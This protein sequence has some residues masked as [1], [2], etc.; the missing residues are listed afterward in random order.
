MNTEILGFKINYT[1]EIDNLD[2]PVILF[3]HGFAD[4]QK[5][6]FRFKEFENKNF[7]FAS[8]DLPGSGLSSTDRHILIED[9]QN[10]LLEFVNKILVAE[11]E[12]YLVSHSLGSASV[13]YVQKHC[14][15]VK[16]VILLAPFH[17]HLIDDTS[18]FNNLKKWLIPSNINDAKESFLNLFGEI[19]PIIEKGAMQYTEKVMSVI[20][21][22]K[23]NFENMVNQQILNKNYLSQNINPLF[24]GDNYFIITG[25][26]DHYVQIESLEKLNNFESKSLV[27]KN[28]G[29]AIIY[30]ASKEIQEF[31]VNM[32]QKK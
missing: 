25:D 15:K 12:I 22:R 16:K 30:E 3:V 29:H 8:L 32:V 1:Y 17:P 21:R 23:I 18:E 20:E 28:K 2:K 31:L 4:T 7:R 11:K 14:E 19:N 13:L 27:L 5:T 24:Q 10:L 26:K 9:F 6:F